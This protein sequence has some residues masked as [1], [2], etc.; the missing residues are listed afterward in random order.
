MREE[1]LGGEKCGTRRKERLC[2][3]IEG[4]GVG[5]SKE[6]VKREQRGGKCKVESGE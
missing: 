2:R 4:Y 5:G 1:E 6:E 3:K